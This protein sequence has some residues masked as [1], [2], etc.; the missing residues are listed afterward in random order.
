[1]LQNR[2]NMS[3]FAQP[4]TF[5]NNWA[6][7]I[8]EPPKDNNPSTEDPIGMIEEKINKNLIVNEDK[9]RVLTGQEKAIKIMEKSG[10]K[11]GKGIGKEETGMITPLIAV[12][13]SSHSAVI[14]NSSLELSDILDPE[15]KAGLLQKDYQEALTNAT[16]IVVLTN[17]IQPV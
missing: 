16:S 14:K 5:S 10:W 9:D 6:N 1:M 15:V 3:G 11:V 17:L 13:N 12:K 2:N 7:P 4:L 8:V